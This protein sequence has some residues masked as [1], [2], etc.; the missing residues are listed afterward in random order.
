MGIAKDLTPE[1]IQ[2]AIW[3]YSATKWQRLRNENE[4]FKAKNEELNIKK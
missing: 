3:N 4:S 1:E 2:F